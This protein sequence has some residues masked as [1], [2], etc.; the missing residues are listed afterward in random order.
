MLEID[1]RSSWLI[2]V[3]HVDN[4]LKFSGSADKTLN[5][6]LAILKKFQNFECPENMKFLLWP[7]GKVTDLQIRPLIITVKSCSG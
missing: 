3:W 6:L 2:F 4:D 7:P 5:K 1:F